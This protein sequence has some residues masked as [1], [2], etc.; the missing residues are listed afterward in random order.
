MKIKSTPGIGPR[1]A[2]DQSQRRLEKLMAQL[3]SGKRIQSASDDA[4][5]MAIAD[6]MNS[7]MRALGQGMRNYS[8]GISYAQ[9]AE[10]ALGGVSDALGRM[11]ELTI[12][13]GNGTLNDSDREIIQQEIDHLAQEIDGIAGGAV[14]NGRRPLLGE[15][16]KIQGRPEE[17]VELSGVDARASAL[18]AVEG[19][20]G[21]SVADIDV[22]TSEGV[23]S[24]L[25]TL[26][27]ALEEITGQRA[28]FGAA[29]SRLSSAIDRMS[30][31]FTDMAE[32]R[33]RVEDLDYAQATAEHAKQQI[34]GNS[35]I[36]MVAQ[37]NIS[38]Q[39][40]ATLLVG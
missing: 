1:R 16:V 36:S 21:T 3:A 4:A 32:V 39:V 33:S 35:G 22:T 27:R 31:A 13:A 9:T 6:R 11:R 8:D 2:I 18:G 38:A 20:E 34:L 5:G 30:G 25:S 24:A 29:Q 40:A 7:E 28:S 15:G 19:E 17:A 23:D 14:F 37:A 10:G 26:D 12:Q